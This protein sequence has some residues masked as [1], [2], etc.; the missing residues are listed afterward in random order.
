MITEEMRNKIGLKMYEN[1]MF[2][3]T[4]IKAEDVNGFNYRIGQVQGLITAMNE[5]YGDDL[6]N[7]LY[8]EAQGK[9]RFLTRN[10]GI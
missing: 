10:G 5:I 6:G 2:A 7:V 1:L 8:K 3:E 9:L 4:C